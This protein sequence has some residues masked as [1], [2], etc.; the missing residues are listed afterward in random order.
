M[1]AS[2]LILDLDAPLIAMGGPRVDGRPQGYRIPTKAMVTGMIANAVGIDRTEVDYLQSLQDGLAMACAILR[3]GEEMVDYQTADLTTPH[4][5][6]PGNK[7]WTASGHVFK[8]AGGTDTL[9]G[10][11]QQWRPYV[12][13]GHFMVALWEI[14]PLPLSLRDAA[15]ALDEP[16]RF[17][18][19]GRK[20]C[21]PNGS[22]SMGVLEAES[23]VDA[24]SKAAGTSRT[25]EFVVPFDHGNP[26]QGRWTPERVSGER[27][28]TLDR[29]A[30]MQ[31]MARI[32]A[33]A[34]H[35]SSTK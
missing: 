2:Y 3:P 35:G 5:G 19:L 29:H 21:P 15:N 7:S 32:S 6:G 1:S 28:W 20:C 9:K 23:P 16:A 33:S 30:G 8:R 4:M 12:A 27:D 17:V 26:P 14:G 31:V 13:D 22:V 18:F 24:L 11:R 10:R 34:V 25:A